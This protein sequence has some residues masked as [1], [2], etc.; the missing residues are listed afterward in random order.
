MNLPDFEQE[1]RRGRRSEQYKVKVPREF[2][3]RHTA[4]RIPMSKDDFI[5]VVGII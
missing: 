4:K 1:L 3:Q 2:S 5:V